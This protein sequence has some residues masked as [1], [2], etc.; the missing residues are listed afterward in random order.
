MLRHREIV[1]RLNR[2][3]LV[4]VILHIIQIICQRLRVAGY[5]DDLI[6]TVAYDLVH[7]V[8]GHADARRIHNDYIRPVRK[9]FKDHKNIPCDKLAV[10]Q[11]IQLC[12]H[13]GRLNGTLVDIDAD[14]V[15]RFARQYLRNGPRPTVKIEHFFVLKIVDQPYSVRIEIL[16]CLHVRLEECKSADLK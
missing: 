16:D 12:I 6:Y 2:P 5:V 9:R 11:S 8:C 14:Y 1:K 7:G 10:F 13:P 4:S 3:H 15:R